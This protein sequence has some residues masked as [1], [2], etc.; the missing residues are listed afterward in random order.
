MNRVSRYTLLS[1]SALK[2]IALMA[3][4]TASETSNCSVAVRGES[5]HFVVPQPVLPAT[6]SGS[7]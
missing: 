7:T 2:S 6:I 1:F 3:L 5:D 4:S